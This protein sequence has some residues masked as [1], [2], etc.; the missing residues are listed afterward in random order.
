MVFKRAPQGSVLLHLLSLLFLFALTDQAW[1]LGCNGTYTNV[2]TGSNNTYN[3]NSN[4]SLKIASGTFTG[5]INN[6]DSTATICIESGATFAPQTLNNPFGQILNYGTAQLASFNYNN[7][8]KLDNYGLWNFNS[9]LNF[10][11]ATSIKNRA[12]ATMTMAN[13]FTLANGSTL[14]NDGFIIAK[15]DFNTNLNTTLKNNYRLEIEGNFN[16]GGVVENNGRTY[17]KKFMNA[18]SGAN[19]TNSCTFISYD[20]FNNNTLF[21]SN[22]GTILI[23]NAAGQPGGAWQN[24]QAFYNGLNAKIAGGNFTNNAA[25]TGYG[26]LIFSGETRNQSTFSGLS[27]SNKIVFYDESQTGSLLFDSYN[28]LAVN[29]IR[30]PLTRPTLL[31]APETCASPFKTLVSVN[32]CPA[33]APN[34][35]QGGTATN[36]SAP[37][38]VENASKA[39]GAL[40]TVNSTAD[41]NNSAKIN[42]NGVLTLDL[43]TTIPADTPILVS[44]AL[45]D[46]SARVKVEVSLDGVTYSTKGTFGSGGT[47]GT[48]T[49]N[50]LSQLVINANLGGTQ[51]VRLMYEAGSMWVDGAEYLQSC[52]EVKDYG[53]A[54]SS[55]GLAAHKLNTTNVYLGVNLPMKNDST[56]YSIRANAEGS[57][58][59]GP[60]AQAPGSPISKFSV[61]QMT[62]TSYST[63]IRTT[64]TSANTATLSGWIDFDKNGTFDADEK[65]TATVPSGSNNIDT[66]LTWASIPSDIKLGTTYV[67]LRYSTDATAVSQPTGT[68]PDGEVEDFILPVHMDIPPNSPSISISSGKTP[69]ACQ[70]VVFEDNFNDLT[71]SST[72]YWGANR[73]GAVAI[74]NWTAA[75]GGTDTYARF[76]DWGLGYGTSI[77]FGNG[78]VRNISPSLGAGFSFDTQGKL[79]TFIDG[80]ALR[81]TIDDI[82]GTS[83]PNEAH[84][85]VLPVSLT[86]SFNTT[87]GKTYRLYFSALRET[88]DSFLAGIMRVD[89]PGG[90]IHFKA[91]GGTEGVLNYAIDFTATSTTSN[92]SFI[93]YGHF[94]PNSNGYCGVDNNAWCTVGGLDNNGKSA[95]ELSIDNV[96]LVEAACTTGGIGGYVYKDANLN[97]NYDM[98]TETTIPSITIKLYD[99]KGTPA[100]TTDDRL[101]TTASTVADGHYLFSD[102]DS[103]VSYR[104]E[105][106]TSDPDLASTLTL[107]TPNPLTGLVPIVSGIKTANFG[108]DDPS[109]VSTKD[110]GD[111]PASYGD[112]SHTVVSGLKLG[113]KA[114]DTDP[115]SQSSFNAL[116]DGLDSDGEDED[117][118]PLAVHPAGPT[119]T[120]RFPVLKVTDTSYTVPFTVTNSTA[121]AGKLYAWIDFD[122]SGTFEADEATSVNVPTSLVNGTLNLVW[123]TIPSDIKI[124]TTF[125]RAR[126]TTDTAV[127]TST[128]TGTASDG[129]VEDHPIA[130]YQ[131]VPSDSNSISIVN[132]ANPLA[133]Q[134]VIFQDDFNT[135]GH[136]LWGAN[137]PSHENIPNWTGSGGGADTYADVRKVIESQGQ[138]VY[139]GSGHLRGIYPQF[140]DGFT[141]DSNGHL[142]SPIEAVALRD[143]PDDFNRNAWTSQWGPELVKLSRTFN[144]QVGK[145]Y[146]LYFKAIPETG[147]YIAGVMRVEA[148]GGSIHF[149]APGENDGI[150]SYAIEFTATQTSSTIAFVNY[151]H[152][153]TDWCDLQSSEW[154]TANGVRNTGP[155]NELNIDDVFLVEAACNTGTISGTVYNDLN[156]N[157]SFDA[158]SESGINAIKVSLYDQN[159]TATDTSDDRLVYTTDSNSSGN[160]SFTTV[161]T[162]R[163][164]RIEVDTE[165]TNLPSGSVIGTT[166]PLTNVS[167]AVNSTTANQNFGFDPAPPPFGVVGEY[168]FDDCGSGS[169]S[170]DSSGKNNAATGEVN[171]LSDDYKSYACTVVSSP[172]WSAQVPHIADYALA[173]GA[174]SL[175]IYDN[176]GIGYDNTEYLLDKGTTASNR[177]TIRPVKTTDNLH[178]S[179]AVTLNGNSIDT[180]ETYYT[181][182]NTT[183]LNNTQWTHVLLSF[184]P[185]GM[186]LYINGVLKGSNAYTG[187]LQN[188][189]GSFKLPGMQGYFDEFYIFNQQPTDAQVQQVYNNIIANKNWDGSE[190]ACACGGVVGDYGDAPA[191]YGAPVHTLLTGMYMGSAMPDTESSAKP[192]LTANGDDTT[193]SDDEEGVSLYPMWQGVESQLSVTVAG[194]GYLQAWMDWNADGDFNDAGEQ[195]ATNLTDGS[196][197]DLSNNTGTISFIVTPPLNAVATDTYARF[198]WSSVQNLNATVAAPDGE[199]EDYLI[200][201][202][203]L[204]AQSCDPS[205]W[206]GSVEE[207][208]GAGQNANLRKLVFSNGSYSA[209]APLIPLG[210][211]SKTIRYSNLG[212]RAQDGYLYGTVPG[213][214]LTGGGILKIGSNGARALLPWP[215]A[216]NNLPVPALNKNFAAGAFGNSGY[217]YMS[218]S[219][220]KFYKVDVTTSPP[221]VVD[222]IDTVGLPVTG[223]QDFV[224]SNDEK[225][226]YGIYG[227]AASD[228]TP[229]AQ[230]IRVSLDASTGYAKG[231]IHYIG[232]PLARPS[233]ISTA[234]TGTLGALYGDLTGN[235]YGAR[236]GDGHLFR[237]DISGMDTATP[238]ATYTDLAVP[239]NIVP[240]NNN[241]GASCSSELFPLA[242]PSDYSDAPSTYGFAKH[243]IVTG[244]SMGSGAPDSESSALNNTNADGDDLDGTDDENGVTLPVFVKGQ[245]AIVTVNVADLPAGGSYLQAWVDWNADGDFLDANEQIAKNLTDNSSTDTNSTSGV[246]RF[247]VAVPEAASS[248]PTYARFRWSSS[249]NIA[250]TGAAKDGEVEDY[251]LTV[252]APPV[253]LGIIGEYRFDDCGSGGANLDSSPKGNTANGTPT[254][255]TED[256]K[257]Y[258]CTS[259]RNDSWNMEVPSI[260]EYALSNGAVSIWFYDYNNI[261]GS[262]RLLE[263]GW[264]DQNKFNITIKPSDEYRRGTVVVDLVTN[265]V[266]KSIDTGETYYTN[267]SLG[268]KNDS[269][270]VNVVVSFGTQGMKLYI[271]GVLKGTNAHTGGIQNVLGNFRLPGFEGY[272]D[273]FY[274]MNQQPSDA[275]VLELY[276]NISANKNWDGSARACACRLVTGDYGDAPLSYGSPVHTVATGI[277]LGS[278]IP[279][280]E[281]ATQA[282]A[283]ANGDDNTGSD[284]EDGITIQ[285][286][287]AGA[288]SLGIATVAGAGYLQAWFDWNKDGDF[289]DS[290]EQVVTNLQDNASGDLSAA[291]GAINF[292]INVPVSAAVGSTYARFRWSTTQNLDPIAAATNGEVED[293]VVTVAAPE[294]IIKGKVWFDS[295]NDGVQNDGT[296]AGIEGAKV[297]LYNPTN[298]TVVATTLT[299]ANGQYQFANAR[300]LVASTA[301]QVRIAK[302]ET[303]APQS[304]WAITSLKTGTDPNLDSDASLSNSYWVIAV[305]SPAAGINGFN[306]FGFSLSTPTGCLNNGLTGVNVESAANSHSNAYNFT[307]NSK[308]VTGYCLE[309]SDASPAVNDSYQVNPSDRQ[310]L[311]AVQK[312]KLSRLYSALHD[313]DIIFAL[314]PVTNGKQQA[315]LDDLLTYMTW[316]YTYYG[317]NLTNV[318]SNH[319]DSNTNFTA[320]QRTVMKAL[321]QKIVD[322]VSGANGEAQYPEQSLFW[323]WNLTDTGRQDI[324]VPAR[325]V[326]DLVCTSTGTITGK[327]YK[328]M[329]TN[330]AFDSTTE[331][332]IAAISVALYDQNGTPNVNNDDTLVSTVVS[333][334]NGAYS[335]INVEANKTYRIQVDTA[336]TDLPSAY[337]IGTSNPLINVTLAANAVESGKDFGFDPPVL[338]SLSGMVF[339][340][341]NYGGGAGRDKATASGVG[342]NG[343]KVE[344]YDSLGALKATA[345][346]ANDGTNNGTYKF[347]SLVQGDYYVRVVSSTVDSTRAGSTGA[348]LGVMTYRSDGAT[349]TSNEVG[350]RNPAL[351]DGAANT[352]SQILDP[353]TSKLANIVPVQ[354][355][356]KITVSGAMTGADFGFNFDT[357]VNTN[358]SGQGSLRQFILNANLLAAESSLA[359]VGLTAGLENSIFMIPGAGPHIITPASALPTLTGTATALN[360]ATQAGAS[361]AASGRILKIGL[362]GTNAGANVSGLVIDAANTVVRGFA[363][364]KFTE[365]GILGTAN[366]DNMSV[367]CNNLGLAPDGDTLKPNGTNGLYVK[368]GASS[369][370]V[371]GNTDDDRNLISG[372]RRDGLRLEGVATATISRNYIGTDTTGTLAR[373]NNREGASYS[374]IYAGQPLTAPLTA[375]SA[376]TIRNN[377]ISGN[378]TIDGAGPIYNVSSGIWLEGVATATITS[379]RIGTDPTGASALANTGYGIYTKTATDITIGGTTAAERNIISANGKDGINT[380]FGTNRITILGN[381]LGTDTTGTVGLGNKDN[382]I[383]L[384]DTQ[385]A[386]IGNSTTAGRN[387]ISANKVG[388]IRNS[389][390]PGTVIAG[391]YIGLDASGSVAMGNQLHGVYV[392]SS[393]S[394]VIGGTAAASRNV[395][396]ANKVIGVFLVGSTS[397]TRVENNIIGLK[398]DG[399]TDAGNL[400]AGIET[401][402]TTGVTI[403][404]NV[405]AANKTRGIHL[406]T[407]PSTTISNNLIG[408]NAAGTLDRGNTSHGI[409]IENGV[410]SLAISNNTI[411]GNG[412]N[413]IFLI[414]IAPNS[415]SFGGGSIVGN[416]IG[417]APDGVTAV[418][419]DGSG[420]WI[421]ASTGV[422]LGG[423]TAADVNTIAYNKGDGIAIVGAGA[424]SNTSRRNSI[425]ANLGLGIDLNN[426][427]VTLNDANDADLGY[428]NDS[429]NFPTLRSARLSGTNM[430]IKGC[431]P[432]GATIELYEADVSVGTAAAGSN[433]FSKS[434]DYG[435]G[436]TFLASLVEGTGSD[437]DS[438]DCSL[439]TDTDGNVSTGMKAFSFT[440]PI[441]AGVV[442]GDL[443]TATAFVQTVGTSEF[444]PTVSYSNANGEIKGTIFEDPNYGGGEGRPLSTSSTV[445][446]NNAVIELYN[447]TGTK[448]ATTT[449]ALSGTTA[450]VYSFAEL[451]D[452]NYFVRVVNNSV[453]SSRAGS[454]GTELGVQTY[455]TDGTNAVLTEVGGRKPNS[456]DAPANTTNQV[457]NVST[458]TFA[459]NTV[460]QTVQPITIAGGEVV[461]VSF[462]FNFSTV[463]NTND[464]GQG[465]LRQFLLNNK[466][467]AT[468]NLAQ[469]LPTVIASEY[470]AGTETSIFMIPATQLTTGKALISLTSGALNVERANTSIDGRTQLANIGSGAIILNNSTTNGVN[471]M[472]T[473]TGSALRDITVSHAAGSG[474]VLDDTDN[475]AIERVAI[476]QN[477]QYGVSL[478]ND[479]L[480][481][482]VVA[483]TIANNTWAGIAHLGTGIGN[484]YSQNS[485]HDNGGL[486]IDLAVDGVTANDNLDSDNGPNKLLNYP[487]V[488]EGSSISSNGTKILAY[489]FDLDV[490]TNSNGYRVEFFRNTTVDTSKYGEGETYLG[491]VDIDSLGGAK[492]N[493]K[494]TLNANQSVPADA[495]ISVTLTEKTSATTL[496]STSE[497]SGVHNGQVS[498]CTDLVNGTGADMTVN[499]NAPVITYLESTDDNG[500]PITYVISGGADGNQFIVQDPEPGATIDCQVVIFR[501]P[502]IIGSRS[503]S[504]TKAAPVLIPGD[505]EIPTDSGGDNT[506][507]LTIT[508]TVNGQDYARPVTVGVQDINEPPSI[509]NEALTKVV[510][511]KTGVALNV[512]SFDADAGD[513]EGKGISYA[514]SGGAD[515]ARFSINAQNGELSFVELPDFEAP[516]DAGNDN[517][518]DVDVRVM[519]DQGLSSISSLKIAIT[520][521]QIN[522]GVNL[523]AKVLLQGPYVGETALMQDSLRS[524][525][526]LPIKQPYTVSPFNYQGT[527]QLNLDLSSITGKDA[528]V[529]WVLLE[530]RNASTGNVVATKAAL[531]QRDGDVVEAATG[532][533][534][535]S[536]KGVAAGNYIVSIRHRNHLGVKTAAAVSLGATPVL[537]DFSSTATKVSGTNARLESNE[538]ALLWG[539]DINHDERLIMMGVGSDITP[540]LSTILSTPANTALNS[541]YVLSAYLETDLNM[542]GVTVLTGQGNDANIVLANVLLFPSNPNHYSNYI[543]AG[544]LAK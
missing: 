78:E 259:V 191:S 238:T 22:L 525:G 24:N 407:S 102:L 49:L 401:S 30:A 372:N 106:D 290:G 198:R 417:V 14:E 203:L 175:L 503:A 75:G 311:T 156:K 294:S 323:L 62:D 63:T 327:V 109:M 258:A 530:L 165:D 396:S 10:N 53:D 193:A 349:A 427:D 155:T 520:D 111:A 151:G 534:V 208:G 450:G 443:L 152:V 283:N 324:I 437:G 254:V 330:N 431:A 284:D 305:T 31:D 448:V 179:V 369:L 440:L 499:E 147:P 424:K 410:A 262:A 119:G 265:G 230:L 251:K 292:A 404:N 304:D 477:S 44:L 539:G 255:I 69:L 274:I 474:I 54:P 271:N 318:V 112:A 45:A 86:R 272:F 194:T 307:F 501:T 114:P 387:I 492:A 483:N 227:R 468:D 77:Y 476:T 127:T 159:G 260:P 92:I 439:A 464:A 110:Y 397:N 192:S 126:L 170:V 7:G 420:V 172:K 113:A 142:T 48:S 481:N 34:L 28:V 224:L 20:G 278:A 216:T 27:S 234:E 124:G 268:A 236:N 532:S 518:Y 456:V 482:R 452:G 209:S 403:N 256:N 138:S 8:T 394:V 493:F 370:Q 42:T 35:N 196:A 226:L 288:N 480:N 428:G 542:D 221:T 146:R 51:Y 144:T 263:R 197:K 245:D 168:R 308:T 166:N 211:P 422:T 132:N 248:N 2:D 160:Y 174:V 398:A 148:P 264:S 357:I 371:G 3:L 281:T 366:A 541:S 33:G 337:V 204:P 400:Q 350:G 244:M 176:E 161:D 451:V 385:N 447:A 306:D 169:W 266:K 182:T 336:D 412:G 128:P 462:G 15:Q 133:C 374:G 297:E 471:L 96:K 217:F 320:D 291:T 38:G 70:S 257:S 296:N 402:A 529:D 261:W 186:K 484:T 527:E 275:Q 510:E 475:A 246:I 85:G 225:W 5:T 118:G 218:S 375:S 362:D 243:I 116:G 285:P 71:P 473:A 334:S 508:A 419:N 430:L 390:T 173:S 415:N 139:F 252:S 391:N 382:G 36:A 479:A 435:E 90:S 183:S 489:D 509:I 516:L 453:R 344:L 12:N 9:S 393:A 446:I 223:P 115:A 103:T 365:A 140:T 232:E 81:D 154:C 328:D 72:S 89:A 514:I 180:G 321:M 207:P 276:N 314:A 233:T 352:G 381:Y 341:I 107:G 130:I 277:Y 206:Y 188:V 433:R 212:Y 300:G 19:I 460:A 66:T 531:V 408:L 360:A 167:V 287:T 270:W 458:F 39:V 131:L 494:G 411:S 50:K 177:L 158:A 359:Q 348:E 141:F 470:P 507:D 190:R 214:V 432:A 338:S 512:E 68:A 185:A 279:D 313:P 117:G 101:V 150:L 535:L 23:T 340:D 88:G 354:N 416:R 76:M 80:I 465:S 466:V 26:S 389:N 295:N 293:Y 378:D 269:Q 500:N 286:L 240:F 491:Y 99:E 108:F 368:V 134:Q 388:G 231:T 540:I 363:I 29:T 273:E 513:E 504:A 319:V 122:K 253:N 32:I 143:V 373:S 409:D 495:N 478:I 17:S 123:S 544:G 459:D 84:W 438:T 485:I 506:Y 41:A 125:I 67:R 537:I 241:D 200:N 13:S 59:D 202:A 406:V 383:F 43:G 157:N 449:S 356:Q 58:E 312:S 87:I 93:N 345:M 137:R 533:T 73:S 228:P 105:V 426:D 303:A 521:D 358:D 317:E 229:G 181:S 219:D 187:G 517:V 235:L 163:S 326:N 441:P 472:P 65:A 502:N 120:M 11:G 21:F 280:T 367:V 505:Y 423:Y 47:L 309:R 199:L 429:L 395:I 454:N 201:V 289:T 414:T 421:E 335:F 16:P 98:A 237:I 325:Y 386:L 195:V 457:L 364:G 538:L 282:N 487:E 490:P 461:G 379:N 74:R 384:A 60:P 405:I 250:A 104:V 55:Y 339:E 351:E 496:G 18:N 64:N 267:Q 57:E 434:K 322:R 247:T 399:N 25:F 95:N 298:S 100:D 61:L 331:T 347:D 40:Q 83:I 205:I 376:I 249:F 121:S 239:A 523:K 329:N 164:Y 222:F 171:V 469:A 353:T 442:S 97:N 346:T 511:G 519:D 4:Q 91:P 82:N 220:A 149:K 332:G 377:L 498:V 1:A 46:V 94:G 56:S 242:Q 301:Y 6:L 380:R 418:A 79:L 536:F 436:Q 342:I 361:C 52:A 444:S 524:L 413:G 467:L 145:S 486:G 425:Y 210:T 184:G 333:D 526:L 522:D 153:G 445:G 543:A 463:V 135:I 355:L 343:A 302:L 178:G 455:R 310:G 497:F 515:R 528:M 162:S 136:R 488:A 392:Q 189:L 316:Y 213:T 37:T 299:N 315:R 129:E 215:V